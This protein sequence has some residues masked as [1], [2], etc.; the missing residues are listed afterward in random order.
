M[1]DVVLYL[2]EPFWPVYIVRKIQS[3]ARTWPCAA[4]PSTAVILCAQASGVPDTCGPAASPPGFVSLLS[5]AGAGDSTPPSVCR[6]FSLT[7]ASSPG[8]MDSFQAP[9]RSFSSVPALAPGVRSED[10]ALPTGTGGVQLRGRPGSS[11]RSSF[12]APLRSRIVIRSGVCAGPDAAS[13]QAISKEVGCGFAFC[14]DRPGSA[15]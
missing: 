14:Y 2:T 13:H 15:A 4:G 11:G 3:A 10:G 12:P 6:F 5:A 1:L 7:S 9:G 8:L